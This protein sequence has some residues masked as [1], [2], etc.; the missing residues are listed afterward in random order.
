MPGS[1]PS[2]RGSRLPYS[3][4]TGCRRCTTTGSGLGVG[5][6]DVELA[7]ERAY[8]RGEA[9]GICAHVLQRVDVDGRQRCRGSLSLN[10]GFG[11][12]CES[13]LSAFEWLHLRWEPGWSASCR[14]S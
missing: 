6:R 7:A 5:S 3:M 10:H 11:D 13:L 1:T 12:S 4:A 9:H 14:A 2:P 8:S